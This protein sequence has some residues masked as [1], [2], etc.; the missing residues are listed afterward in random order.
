VLPFF[1]TEDFNSSPPKDFILLLYAKAQAQ[2]FVS[3]VSPPR[4]KKPLNLYDLAIRMFIGD[5]A[6]E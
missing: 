3:Y 1:A 5:K 4:L 2:V 6:Q